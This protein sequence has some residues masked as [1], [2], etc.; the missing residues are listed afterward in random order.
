MKTPEENSP[1]YHEVP[2]TI[3]SQQCRMACFSSLIDEL[4][5]KTRFTRAFIIREAL[6]QYVQKN[7]YNE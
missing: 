7:L 1:F 4:I 5:K 6:Y 3:H 2:E